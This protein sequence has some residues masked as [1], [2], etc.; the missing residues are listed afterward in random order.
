MTEQKILMISGRKQSGKDSAANYLAGYL[1]KKAGIIKHFELD[2]QGKLLINYKFLDPETNQEVEELALLDLERKD[3]EFADSASKQ[4]W[5]LIKQEKFGNLLKDILITVF[6][7]DRS[8]VY[9]S[10]DDKNKL[11]PLKWESV[12]KLLPNL[13]PKPQKKSLKDKMVEAKTEGLEAETMPSAPE[14]L[15]NRQAMEIVGTDIFRTLHNLCWV[16]PLFRQITEQGFPLVVISDCRNQDEI[17]YGRSLGAKIVRLTRN[18]FN[19]QHAIEIALDNYTEF[20]LVI[21]NENMT[22]EQKGAE[23]VNWLLSIGWV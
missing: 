11:S 23:L 17:E 1:L 18:P 21:D 3:V 22:Q 5:P 12:Y 2:Q 13:R 7:L 20:D 19:G 10:D 14:F 8:E 15:T 4:V 16:E 9:G 6:G